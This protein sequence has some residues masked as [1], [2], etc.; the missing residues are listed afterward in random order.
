MANFFDVFPK[1]LYDIGG[2]RLTNYSVT[3][4]IFFRLRIIREV[5]SNM[6][7]YYEYLI[8]DDETPEI[9]AE[10][11]YG[12][13]EAH[14]IILM[15]N[16]I[17]D[18]QYDWPLNY[19]QFNN[20]IIKKYGSI[21]NAQTNI[22]HYEKVLTRVEELSDIVYESRFVVNK[23]KLTVNDM[24]VPYD[25][26]QGTG[27][28][29]ETQQFTTYNLSDGSTVNETIRRNEI[30]FYDYEQELNEKKR[31]IKIIKPEYYPQL[32]REFNSLI[33]NEASFIR[34]LT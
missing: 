11:V 5:L 32:I 19:D 8:A 27:S 23:E 25:Y 7:S 6:S 28:L 20:Y 24:T 22:H 30:S 16:D 21:E 1:I 26:Y 15:A 4:N 17:L 2:K 3:T 33:G 31:S 9:L 10:K 12:N 18:P 14:W 13:P 34:R 29:P